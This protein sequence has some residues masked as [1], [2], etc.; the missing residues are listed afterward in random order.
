MHPGGAPE[1]FAFPTEYPR[2]TDGSDLP[3]GR[4]A[5]PDTLGVPITVQVPAGWSNCSLGPEEVG[6]CRGPE[7]SGVA[8]SVVVDVLEDPCEHVPSDPPLGP[9]VDDLV[10]AIIGLDGFT[11]T[12]PEVTTVDGHP[13]QRLTVMAPTQYVCTS[14]GDGLGTWATA[15]RVNGVGLGET[16]ELRVLEVNGVRVLIAAAYGSTASEALR[17]EVRDVLDSVRIG[18]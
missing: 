15:S 2:L 14:S 5:V 17:D 16:N 9:G 12:E 18:R 3:A 7:S 4:Y 11:S 13:A 1:E 6:V 10:Q 8:F